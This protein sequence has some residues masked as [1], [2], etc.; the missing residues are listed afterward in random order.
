MIWLTNFELEIHEKKVEEILLWTGCKEV[1]A[2]L[3]TLF[4]PVL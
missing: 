3:Y 1:S 2:D 4:G